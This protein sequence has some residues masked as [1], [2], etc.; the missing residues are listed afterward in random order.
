MK[1][2]KERIVRMG[3]GKKPETIECLNLDNKKI[4]EFST[5]SECVNLK[6]LSLKYNQI[7]DIS[8]LTFCTQLWILDLQQNQVCSSL[9]SNSN[10]I[11]I[12]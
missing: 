9:P 11:L 4:C 6:Y 10:I 12:I 7:K 8:P 5:I 1:L 3:K 2:T